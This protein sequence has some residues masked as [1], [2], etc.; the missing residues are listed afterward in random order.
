[1]PI[2]SG[3][4]LPRSAELP[5]RELAEFLKALFCG[6]SHAFRFEFSLSPVRGCA[7][8]Y[9]ETGASRGRCFAVGGLLRRARPSSVRGR[10]LHPPV[11][12]RP[13]A[14]LAPCWALT[15]FRALRGRSAA[16]GLRLRSQRGAAAAPLRG[17]GPRDGD[18]AMAAICT[19]H[20]LQTVR[21]LS[22][23]QVLQRHPLHILITSS[24]SPPPSHRLSP[25]RKSSGQT[26]LAFE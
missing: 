14:R 10:P 9:A 11:S 19:D 13:L 12:A 5:C 18:P 8:S 25:P 26:L 16:L 4:G 24:R 15:G 7:G 3:R 20:P 1:V 2:V 23:L 17:G 22:L 6:L 21:T